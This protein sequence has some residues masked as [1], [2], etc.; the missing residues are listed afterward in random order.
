MLSD[1]ERFPNY[2]QFLPSM[3]DLSLSY[4]G[5]S[6]EFGWRHVVIY[7]QDEN[8]FT[9]VYRFT[10]IAIIYKRRKGERE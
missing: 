10:Y 5:I 6:K 7:L 1:R 3:V 8:L 9:L 4:V 2:Y